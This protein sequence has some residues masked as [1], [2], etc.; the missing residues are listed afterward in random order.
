MAVFVDGPA[1]GVALALRLAPPLLRAVQTAGGSWDALDQ[2]GDTPAPGEG[3]WAYRR[4]GP[5]TRAHLCYRGKLRGLSGWYEDA[6]YAVV[7]P[8]PDDEVLRDEGRWRAWCAA[9]QAGAAPN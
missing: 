4:S 2:P 7:V 1:S 9:Q 3:V 8:Q 6:R 5:I